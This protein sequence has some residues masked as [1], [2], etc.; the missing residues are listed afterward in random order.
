MLIVTSQETTKSH[1]TGEV[2]Y[3][4]VFI[5]AFV[6]YVIKFL[7]DVDILALNQTHDLCVKL[8]HHV[9]QCFTSLTMMLSSQVLWSPSCWRIDLI[10]SRARRSLGGDNS[11]THITAK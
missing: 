8:L 2:V 6:S 5:D 1:P 7:W 9:T 4:L 11:V 3:V 10:C